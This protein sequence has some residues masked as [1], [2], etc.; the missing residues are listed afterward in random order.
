MSVSDTLAYV[1]FASRSV[2][3]YVRLS[4]AHRRGSVARQIASIKRQTARRGV[5]VRA[6][7]QEGSK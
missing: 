2:V 4:S 1:R 5:R 7:Y 6:I 3:A